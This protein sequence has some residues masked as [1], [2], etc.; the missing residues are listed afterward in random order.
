MKLI[1]VLWSSIFAQTNFTNFQCQWKIV[2][3]KQ[4][5]MIGQIRIVSRIHALFVASQG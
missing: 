4:L 5:Y 2:A 3:G 1:W